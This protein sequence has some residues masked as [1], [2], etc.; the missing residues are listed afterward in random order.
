MVNIYVFSQVWEIV[1]WMGIHGVLQRYISHACI[2]VIFRKMTI[3]AFP[4]RPPVCASIPSS[5]GVARRMGTDRNR[6][7]YYLLSRNM[8]GKPAPLLKSSSSRQ[9][10]FTELVVL[11]SLHTEIVLPMN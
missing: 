3:S 1:P 2:I 8:R 11:S 4:I 10:R 7:I 5:S 6:S 9:K